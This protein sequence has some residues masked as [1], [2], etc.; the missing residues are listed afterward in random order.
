MQDRTSKEFQS[1]IRGD[2]PDFK[3]YRKQIKIYFDF[4]KSK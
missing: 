4:F 1:K 2:S 3:S